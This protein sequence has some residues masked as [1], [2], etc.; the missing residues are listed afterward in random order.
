MFN[1]I[2]YKFIIGTIL[3]STACFASTEQL[4]VVDFITDPANSFTQG[5]IFNYKNI[6]SIKEHVDKLIN[7]I[8]QNTNLQTKLLRAIAML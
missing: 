5:K 2:I 6:C 8:K 1:N 7:Q 3:L 4:R